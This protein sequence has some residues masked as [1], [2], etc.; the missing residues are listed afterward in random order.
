MQDPTAPN[1]LVSQG[2]ASIL[3]VV[4]EQRLAE[5][6]SAL[7]GALVTLRAMQPATVAQVSAKP[8]STQ[9]QKAAR[10]D[11]WS[12]LPLRGWSDMEHW[13]ISMSDHFT[14]EQPQSIALP[15]SGSQVS[16]SPGQAVDN[17]TYSPGMAV[18]VPGPSTYGWQ[19]REDINM[20]SP[21]ETHLHPPA[22][23]S[24]PVYSRHQGVGGSEGM[25]SPADGISEHA[26]AG[27]A[28]RSEN[29][30]KA[31]HADRAED[32]SKNN[33]CIYF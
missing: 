33:P 25:A 19:S 22:M 24:S 31:N 21:Y 32:L 3:K 29:R 11:E 4:K 9:K 27:P 28:G 2:S 10:M 23:M 5:T 14:I 7:Y 6:E 12:Q 15:G 18:E 20:N 30:A 8:D 16:V 13:M 26:P 17:E 1:V